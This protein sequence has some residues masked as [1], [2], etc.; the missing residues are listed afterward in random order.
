MKM[1]ADENRSEFSVGPIEV[2][3]FEKEQPI[4]RDIHRQPHPGRNR[5]N[6]EWHEVKQPAHHLF[7]DVN[8]QARGNGQLLL[9]VMDAVERP[10]KW[11][12]MDGPMPQVI[13]QIGDRQSANELQGRRKMSQRMRLQK[14]HPV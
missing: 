13:G 6:E 10:Q 11:N 5:Q 3:V 7:E 2:G 8:A 12:R 1:G 9:R 4:D 14:R